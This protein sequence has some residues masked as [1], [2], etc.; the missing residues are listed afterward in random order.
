MGGLNVRFEGPGGVV[1]HG[2]R[3]ARDLDLGDR[4]DLDQAA[5]EVRSEG[6]ESGEIERPNVALAVPLG[7]PRGAILP[8][9]AARG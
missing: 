3:D 5:V 6:L 2:L 1:A 9:G 8:A 4:R 7:R